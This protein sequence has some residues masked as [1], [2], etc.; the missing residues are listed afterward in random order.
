MAHQR[1]VP[2]RRPA[3]PYP[4][5]AQSAA[6]ENRY[7]LLKDHGTGHPPTSHASHRREGSTTRGGARV[8]PKQMVLHMPPANHKPSPSVSERAARSAYHKKAV[9]PP[10]CQA[11]PKATVHDSSA[12]HESKAGHDSRLSLETYLAGKLPQMSNEKYR[13]TMD[14]SNGPLPS[15]GPTTHTFAVK[16][17][18]PN[19][20]TMSGAAEKRARPSLAPLY[21]LFPRVSSTTTP[22]SQ[23]ATPVPVPSSANSVTSGY[24]SPLSAVRTAFTDWTVGR[25]A[26]KA[27]TAL[28]KAQRQRDELVAQRKALISRPMKDSLAY[29]ATGFADVHRKLPTTPQ[30]PAMWSPAPSSVASS[31]P[32]TPLRLLHKLVA[33][34]SRRFGDA[35]DDDGMDFKCSGEDAAFAGMMADPLLAPAPLNPARAAAPLERVRE[36]R[37]KPLPPSPTCFV[38]RCQTLTERRHRESRHVPR[39]F[40]LDTLSGYAASSVYSEHIPLPPRSSRR[41]PPPCNEVCRQQPTYVS[42]SANPY[43]G[44]R[45]VSPELDCVEGA[46]EVSPVSAGPGRDCEWQGRG[47]VSPL[48]EHK[49]PA[50]LW[51]ASWDLEKLPRVTNKRVKELEL[52]GFYESLMKAAAEP[53]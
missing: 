42:G 31:T 8:A 23:P 9:P 14:Y 40:D 48:Q 36:A 44:P 21:T 13:F 38:P 10:S 6:S 11:G 45:S 29:D 12:S 18:G 27:Q 47:E 22:V 41:A 28:E 39:G 43:A 26:K 17:P 53:I 5:S 7:A 2:S 52:E 16:K 51:R 20:N 4:F 1:S 33:K 32:S 37:D 3:S 30:R 35:D 15:P 46:D 34:V 25:K 49:V 19:V 50:Y 24:A